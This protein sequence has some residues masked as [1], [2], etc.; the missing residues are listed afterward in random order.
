MFRSIKIVAS[1]SALAALVACGGSAVDGAPGKSALSSLTPEPRGAECPAG[2][3]RVATGVDLDGNGVLDEVEVKS[4]QLLCN[5]ASGKDGAAGNSGSAVSSLVNIDAEPQGAN[6]PGG[7]TRV[8]SGLDTDGNRLLEPSEVT[9]SRYICN[10]AEE[11]SS[12]AVS[13]Y[14]PDTVNVGSP[15]AVTVLSAKINAPGKGKLIALSNA[16]LFCASPALGLGHDCAASGTTR[17]YFTLSTSASANPASGSY[18]FFYVTP[19]STDNT[20]RT[21]VFD[22]AAAG[23]MN[24]YLRASATAG[25]YGLFRTSL[26]LLFIPE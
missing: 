4:S 6:C 19:N 20:A 24:V 10:D 23:E 25:Q 8:Q 11:P 2:G 21:A 12:E 17:G 13:V 14:N 22:V 3:T 9:S 1:F 18:D 15:T 16:D 26:T 5:G 7:G